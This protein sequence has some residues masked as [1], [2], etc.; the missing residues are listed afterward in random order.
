MASAPVDALVP[1]RLY[2]ARLDAHE[3]ASMLSSH[4]P[5]IRDAYKPLEW[6]A[7]SRRAQ[8]AGQVHHGRCQEEA[9]HH[10]FEAAK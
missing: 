4:R 1:S 8:G 9:T 10:R 7:P 3:L 5:V 2:S 6:S